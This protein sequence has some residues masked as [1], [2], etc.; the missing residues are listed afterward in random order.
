MGKS[1]RPPR[2]LF[3]DDIA[4][5]KLIAANFAV[6]QS[7]NLQEDK[8]VTKY[9]IPMLQ[10]VGLKINFLRSFIRILHLQLIQL[11]QHYKLKLVLLL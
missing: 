3:C 9:E 11:H 10:M 7:G 6:Q 1:Y 8:F 2:E 4:Q 5:S